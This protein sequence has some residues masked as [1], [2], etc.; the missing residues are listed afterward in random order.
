MQDF[1]EFTSA[2]PWL[3]SGLFAS[4][5]AVLFYELR[6]KARNIGSVSTAMAVKL[7]NSGCSVVDLRDAEKFAAGHIVDSQNIPESDVADA[8]SQ[9]KKGD[10]ATLVVCDTGDK[11]GELAG[12]LRKDGIENAYSITGGLDAWL[13][14]NLPVVSDTSVAKA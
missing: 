8:K 12:R 6:M 5:L 2:N 3:I 1:V 4:G 10:K 11:S 13:R 14:D 7:I 9:Q